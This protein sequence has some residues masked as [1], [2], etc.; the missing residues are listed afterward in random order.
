MTISF[1]LLHSFPRK[2]LAFSKFKN[3]LNYRNVQVFIKKKKFSYLS[4]S[5]KILIFK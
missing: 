5:Y 1:D 2:V 4:N 3:I